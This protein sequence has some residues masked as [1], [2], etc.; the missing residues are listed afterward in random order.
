MFAIV[1]LDHV[2][3][4]NIILMVIKGLQIKLFTLKLK[5][6][7]IIN[8]LGMDINEIQLFIV[9]ETERER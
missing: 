3:S 4:F 2:D 6:E 7:K 8:D 5:V 1:G 9:H